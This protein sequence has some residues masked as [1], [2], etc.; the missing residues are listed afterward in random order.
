MDDGRLVFSGTPTQLAATAQGRVW[1]SDRP[2]ASSAQIS[3]RTGEG[4]WRCLGTPP[5][6]AVLGEPSLEDGYLLLVGR[7]GVRSEAA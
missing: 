2:P 1:L 6:D 5:P 7:S 4:L 3:W